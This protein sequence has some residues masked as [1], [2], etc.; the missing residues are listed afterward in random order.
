MTARANFYPQPS[1]VRPNGSQS[2]FA[3]HAAWDSWFGVH[4]ISRAIKAAA[5]V[6]NKSGNGYVDIVVPVTAASE[7][8]LTKLRVVFV[9]DHADV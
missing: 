7:L 9:D 4:N 1:A 5:R 3:A 2:S 8:A 6:I